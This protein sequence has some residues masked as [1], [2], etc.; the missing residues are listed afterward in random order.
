MSQDLVIQIFRDFLKSTLILM[1]PLL[2]AS[3]VVGLLISI[4]QAA[5]QIQE[6]TLSY[7]PKIITAMVL[8]IALGPWMIAR[9]TGFARSLYLTIPTLGG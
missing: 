5:T 3:I 9:L 7:V 1:S 4:F 6:I 2:I 8:L